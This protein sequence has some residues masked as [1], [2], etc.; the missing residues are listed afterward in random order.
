MQS[1]QGSHLS[2]GGAHEPSPLPEKLL[3]VADVA[4]GWGES[5][6]SMVEPLM[7]YPFSSKQPSTHAHAGNPGYTQWATASQPNKRKQCEI[8]SRTWLEAGV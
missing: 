7:T 4:G 5:Y 3:A 1:L 2:Q 8:G 6:S